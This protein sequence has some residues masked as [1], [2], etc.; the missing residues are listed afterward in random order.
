MNCSMGGNIIAT[1]I[2]LLGFLSGIGAVATAFANKLRPTLIMLLV[3][4]MSMVVTRAFLRDMYLD[5]KFSLDSL[6]LEPQYGVMIL[7]FIIL[8]IGLITVGYMLKAGFTS[9]EGRTA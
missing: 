6:Q 1:L 5:G 3:T 8:L 7:F 9:K 2:F 4:I